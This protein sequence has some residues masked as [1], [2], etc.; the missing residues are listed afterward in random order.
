M[1]METHPAHHRSFCWTC[2][3]KLTDAILRGLHL[4]SLELSSQD[5]VTVAWVE[6]RS[7][8]DFSAQN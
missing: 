3:L 1:R 6:T 8:E 4:K 2:K 5:L 7:V